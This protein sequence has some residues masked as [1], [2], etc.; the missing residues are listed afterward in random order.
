MQKFKA[1]FLLFVATAVYTSSIEAWHMGN[2][3]VG[4]PKGD[5]P[6]GFRG[7]NQPRMSDEDTRLKA[8]RHR[9]EDWD[10]YPYAE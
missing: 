8:K 9:Y 1:V 10:S 7:Y 4:Q 3:Q 5:V 2:N 6:K